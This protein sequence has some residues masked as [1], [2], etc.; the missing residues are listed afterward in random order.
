MVSP[1][2]ERRIAENQK[3]RSENQKKSSVG[4]CVPCVLCVLCDSLR[5]RLDY[6]TTSGRDSSD[7]E[8]NGP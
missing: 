6:G 7:N 2:C 5:S 4:L 8:K 1:N 3:G